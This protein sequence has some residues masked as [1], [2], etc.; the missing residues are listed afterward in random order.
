MFRR[1]EPNALTCLR[2]RSRS[3]WF[4]VSTAAYIYSPLST[5]PGMAQLDKGKSREEEAWKPGWSQ[6]SS[7]SEPQTCVAAVHSREQ[8]IEYYISQTYCMDSALYY[9]YG[10]SH[11]TRSVRASLPLITA[12]Y[13]TVS[14]ACTIGNLWASYEFVHMPRR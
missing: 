13:S 3:S 11:T 14:G 6:F 1:G 5:V 4:N 12:V 8:D 2:L 10:T 7:L 9:T